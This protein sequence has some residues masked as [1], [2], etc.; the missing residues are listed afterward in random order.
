ML[1]KK[2][3]G[4]AKTTRLM[5]GLAS[6]AGAAVDRRTFLARSGLLTGGVA[7]ASLCRARCKR[8][9]RLRQAR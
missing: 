3:S 7:M 9:T 5:Q 1:R 6:V 8:P 2:S 4:T